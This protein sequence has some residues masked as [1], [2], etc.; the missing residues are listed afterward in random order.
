MGACPRIGLFGPP[1]VPKEIRALISVTAERNCS[2][3]GLVLGAAM[4]AG[5]MSFL[6]VTR[7]GVGQPSPVAANE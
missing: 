4:I 1:R 7:V 5:R 6:L 3:G 2:D